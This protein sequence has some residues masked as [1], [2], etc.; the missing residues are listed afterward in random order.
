MIIYLDK[1]VYSFLR[2]DSTHSKLE[3]IIKKSLN[4]STYYYSSAHIS[5]LKSDKTN[6]KFEE[7]EYIG[8]LIGT[9]YFAKYWNT[10]TN[11]YI[12]K[13]VDA[14]NDL[15]NNSKKSLFDID[16]ILDSPEISKKINEAN[17]DF[18]DIDTS[19]LPTEEILNKI[20]NIPVEL[21]KYL[22]GIS[23]Q[24]KSFDI[25]ELLKVSENFFLSISNDN[26]TYRSLRRYIKLNH[27]SLFESLP[28]EVNSENINELFNDSIFKTTFLEYLEKNLS[29]D[30]KNIE[31]KRYYIFSMAYGLI[32]SLA[33]DNEPNRKAKFKNTHVDGEHAYYAGFCDLL[34]TDDVGLIEKAQILYDIFKIDTKILH[35]NDFENYLLN[36]EK[37]DKNIAQTL[38]PQIMEEIKNNEIIYTNK[39]KEIT[40]LK[41]KL[42]DPIIGNFRYLQCDINHITNKVRA[43][44]LLSSNKR[45]GNLFIYDEIKTLTNYC[46]SIFG[47][48]NNETCGFDEKEI[49]DIQNSKWSG[50][51]WN[52]SEGF[53]YL[54][55][56]SESSLIYLQFGFN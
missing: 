42:K 15:I 11:C 18:A 8:N 47:V 38:L 24:V 37:L 26:N 52:H 5:D 2:K 10:P 28:D 6:I 20:P 13:P 53:I 56:F 16:S 9:N 12:A 21:K 14:F 51:S 31:E 49:Q 27:K 34:V 43:L 48:D 39:G 25:H 3:E 33:L 50:R 44:N 7:L 29:V 35:F 4:H 23:K 30:V 1:N 41:Y 45:L 22:L 46:Y 32:N 36:I 17:K 55:L 40:Q 54:N 19:L